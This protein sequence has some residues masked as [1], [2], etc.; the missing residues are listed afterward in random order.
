MTLHMILVVREREFVPLFSFLSRLYLLFPG[1]LRPDQR[2][3]Q[4]NI[5]ITKASI[6]VEVVVVVV[7]VA[8]A[9]VFEF[10][11]GTTRTVAAR[12]IDGIGPFY[13]YHCSAV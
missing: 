6:V 10:M 4:I 12:R 5:G 11:K 9:T 7:T 13:E 8:A 3:S 2:S 1:M